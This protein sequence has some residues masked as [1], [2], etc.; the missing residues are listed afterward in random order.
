MNESCLQKS[1]VHPWGGEEELLQIAILFFCFLDKYTIVTIVAGMT[2]KIS[3]QPSLYRI[4]KKYV[5]PSHHTIVLWLPWGQM[6]VCLVFKGMCDSCSKLLCWIKVVQRVA[7]VTHKTQ[8]S[9][10]PVFFCEGW[11]YSH[12]FLGFQ[13][14]VQV[15]DFFLDKR[16][17]TCHVNTKEFQSY[18]FS[19]IS[20]SKYTWL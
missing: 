7:R 6:T 1:L 9:S 20:Q 11:L 2:L 18:Y 12:L 14:N 16:Y 5:C 3:M 19:V 13:K 15:P 10:S 17:F 4:A 8:L